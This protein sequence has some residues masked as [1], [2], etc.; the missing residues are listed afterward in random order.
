MIMKIGYLY[1]DDHDLFY[2][3][4]EKG[5]SLAYIV[6]KP[7]K[8]SSNDKPGDKGLVGSRYDGRNVKCI[9]KRDYKMI[10]ELYL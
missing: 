5:Q 6:I 4:G 7:Y 1:E 8:G 9:G 10:R 3:Y 2:I